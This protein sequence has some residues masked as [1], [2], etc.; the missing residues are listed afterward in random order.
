MN[1]EPIY[2]SIEEF[3]S[4]ILVGFWSLSLLDCSRHGIGHLKWALPFF[5]SGR[6]FTAQLSLGLVATYYCECSNVRLAT[7]GVHLK[8]VLCSFTKGR[9]DRLFSA[10]IT[11]VTLELHC[12]S[13]PLAFLDSTNSLS[14][15]HSSQQHAVE[16]TTKANKVIVC[17]TTKH[18]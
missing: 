16:H 2:A 1:Y 9:W 15:L 11:I 10:A 14:V 7:C 3:H 6:Q 17:D 5:C 13:V 8:I 18:S 4:L 12:Q